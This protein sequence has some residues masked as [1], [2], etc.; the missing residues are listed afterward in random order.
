MNIYS[1]SEGVVVL[2]LSKVLC[3]NF[4]DIMKLVSEGKKIRVV[5]SHNM[6]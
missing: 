2:N 5:G 3:E 6:N 1:T 4:E